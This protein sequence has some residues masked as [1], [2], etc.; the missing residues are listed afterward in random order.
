MFDKIYKQIIADAVFSGEASY[1]SLQSKIA[2]NATNSLIIR[3]KPISTG[4]LI[5]SGIQTSIKKK[6]FLYCVTL[7]DF[8]NLQFLGVENYFQF[9][10]NL[11]ILNS[12]STLTGDKFIVKLHPSQQ[13]LSFDLKPLYPNL[14]FSNN[15]IKKLLK[16]A[17]GL[18]SFSS[19]SIEDAITSKVPV[20]LFDLSKCY[21]HCNSEINV[22]KINQPIYYVNNELDFIKSIKTIQ[23]SNQICF[24]TILI[25]NNQYFENI[26]NLFLTLGFKCKY[27]FFKKSILNFI[28]K[29]NIL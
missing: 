5:F 1:T 6:Y 21:K 27:S 20:I 16:Y 4:N 29:L 11:K 9:L 23:K 22:N 18:I 19:T 15:S 25:N 10:E 28:Y 26:F 13:K 3:S 8:N 17:Y 12:V 7:K 14:I 24:N 2:V